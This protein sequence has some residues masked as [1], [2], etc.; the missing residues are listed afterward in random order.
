MRALSPSSFATAA[1][2]VRP[3]VLVVL[4][5]ACAPPEADQADQADQADEL[6]ALLAIPDH[7]ELPAIPEANLPTAE[8]IALG[9]HL[10]YDRRLSGNETQA[11]V[12]CHFA[13]LAFA[14]DERTPTGSTG[15]TLARNSQGLGNV[16]YNSSLTWASDGLL[17][18]EDQLHVPIR[19]DDP[20]ELGVNDEN[21]D[22]VLARFDQDPEYARMFDAAFPNSDSGATVNKIVLALASFCRRMTTGQSPYDR[23]VAGERSALDEQQRRGMT[24]FNGERF[25][26]FHCHGGINLTT[27]YRDE[28]TEQGDLRLTFFNT[29]LYDVDG[30]GSYPAHDQGLYELTFDPE[31]RGLFRPPSLRNVAMTPPYM[32]DGSIET[33]QEVV[34]HYAAGGRVIEDGPFAGDGRTSPL[35]SGLV[36][37]FSATDEEIDAVVAFLEALT[38]PAFLEDEALSD[39][40]GGR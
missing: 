21:R 32:H 19:A 4:L 27:S 15:S 7:M 34:E 11:C 31:H 23:F 22:E 14:D 1:A 5:G 33:L 17:S 28:G 3:G 40:W 6:R 37:G 36:R 25:E 13:H 38:D 2:L 16:A 30:E 39:P 18:L 29:G 12:D 9:R 35:K 10:F 8:K 26:C 20:V 24:L